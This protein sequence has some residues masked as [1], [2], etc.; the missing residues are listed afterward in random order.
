MAPLDQFRAGWQLYERVAQRI[1]PAARTKT[2]RVIR[3]ATA[4]G[5][6]VN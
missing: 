1:R 4:T 3:P 2:L 6:G 5:A